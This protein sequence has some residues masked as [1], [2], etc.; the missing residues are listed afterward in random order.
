MKT[1]VQSTLSYSIH[2]KNGYFDWNT[3]KRFYWTVYFE[4]KY[5]TVSKQ[6]G[7]CIN[8]RFTFGIKTIDELLGAT[9]SLLVQVVE[10]CSG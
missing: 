8:S 5:H 2:N 4:D 6:E 1:I 10:D 9:V 7:D 3:L